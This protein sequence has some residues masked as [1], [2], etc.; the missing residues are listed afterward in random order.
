ML[1]VPSIKPTAGQNIY[2]SKIKNLFRKSSDSY[3]MAI[4]EILRKRE[5]VTEK[6]LQ[7]ALRVQKE[8]LNIL[9][10]AVRLGQIIVELGYASEEE[11]VEA[12]NQEYQISVES[13]K[14]DIKGQVKERRGS[15]VEGLPA[16]RVPIW[17]QL[18]AATMFIIIITISLLSFVTLRQQKERLYKQTIKI[19]RV[20]LNY[21]TSNASVPLLDDN[22]LRL[23]TLIKDAAAV[24]GLI[25]AIIIDH[26]RIV[27]AHT[28][29]RKIDT[30]FEN[31][32]DVKDV[33]KE[34][35]FTYFDYI[36]TSGE[37]ILN[38]TRPIVFKGKTLGE[39]HVGVSI[40]FIK[41]LINKE[42]LTIILLSFFI[43]LIGIA[44]ATLLGF[45]FSKPIS[46]LVLAT[47]EIG[48][49][50]Y[51]HK[52]VLA[53]NDELGNL[54][55]AFNRMGSE[56]WK[57]SLMQ[58]SF[59]KYVGSEVLDMI[60]ADPESAWLKGRKNEATIVFTDI[61]GFTSYSEANEPE[62]IVER[63]N[64]YFEIATRSIQD[65]GGYVDKFIGDAVL[66]VFG[67][68]IYHQDHVERA[69]KASI[70][71]QEKFQQEK[72]NGKD[73]LQS[74]GIGINTGIVV[75]GNIGSA[76]KMEY[77]V[78]GDSVNVASRLNGLAKSG[79]IIISKSVY[80]H[81]IDL[82]DVEVLS[83]QYIKGKSEPV[84]TFKVLGIKEERHAQ[85][86]K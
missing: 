49:G 39:V 32:N 63:L 71:M 41:Q 74:V 47:Q 8:K 75:S 70:D 78:I 73:I 35:G 50:N 60:M 65:H 2:L 10:R 43:V 28:D 45:R 5:I 9:G 22:I 21:F 67:V 38:L 34:E 19:G 40:D 57:N 85:D 16:P 66:G 27:K 4:G 29:I 83:L 61:R 82:I 1:K 20:S 30:A 25:Y 53:R 18:F 54:A 26:N 14:D 48:V 23:N 13:L 7:D 31:F 42:R 11:L 17:L 76:N 86:R 37:H 79:E 64:E 12:V 81:L 33:K 68:P 46:H 69:V 55:T 15:F 51:R 58:K 59:G 77:T 3:R 62:I 72:E 52:I 44:I 36:S 80:D 6:Q 84:E 56:L 24:E